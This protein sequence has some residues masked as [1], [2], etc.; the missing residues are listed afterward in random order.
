M[1][2][3]LKFKGGKAEI[4][5]IRIGRETVEVENYKRTKIWTLSSEKHEKSA[6]AN[7]E[8]IL[9]ES[10]ISILSKFS[11]PFLSDCHVSEDASL[12]LDKE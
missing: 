8:I 1:R 11:G 9:D 3:V 12:D 4:P 5:M 2:S 10:R 7:I 6:I